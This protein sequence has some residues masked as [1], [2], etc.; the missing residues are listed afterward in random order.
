MWWPATEALYGLLKV[1]HPDVLSWQLD[2]HLADVG[3]LDRELCIPGCCA[4]GNDREKNQ[5][6]KIAKSGRNLHVLDDIWK[7]LNHFGQLLST[8]SSIYV[9]IFQSI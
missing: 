4:T 2:V 8:K 7:N 6:Q 1:E 5:G 9:F 3:K